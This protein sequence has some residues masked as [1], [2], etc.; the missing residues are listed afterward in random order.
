M[1]KG[2]KVYCIK[3]FD[4]MFKADMI[5]YIHHIG[6]NSILIEYNNS[7]VHFF[8]YFYLPC[9]DFYRYR[10]F[11]DYFVT[12]KGQRNLKLDRILRYEKRR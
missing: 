3:N 7:S 2:D 11:Y 4:N 1:K 12:I 10:K 5:Y 9:S 8:C 6:D